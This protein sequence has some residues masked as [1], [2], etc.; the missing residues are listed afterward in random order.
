MQTP[1]GYGTGERLGKF[2]DPSNPTKPAGG[3]KFRFRSWSGPAASKEAQMEIDVGQ[4]TQLTAEF[5]VG[6]EK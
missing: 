3:K 4:D 1:A 6:A 2:M 5:D